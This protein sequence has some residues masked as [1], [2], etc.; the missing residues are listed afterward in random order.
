LLSSRSPTQQKQNQQQQQT[1][2][3]HSLKPFTGPRDQHPNPCRNGRRETAATRRRHSQAVAFVFRAKLLHV[4]SHAG[5]QLRA[6]AAGKGAHAVAAGGGGGGGAAPD[7][8]ATAGGLEGERSRGGDLRVA[9]E[10]VAGGGEAP[11]A[12]DRRGGG[13]DRAPAG[14]RGG[15]GGVRDACGEGGG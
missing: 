1:L 3:H 7:E 4:S 9:P 15:A 5:K 11:A 10:R 14:A 13:G 12:A 2:H 6:G 8:V